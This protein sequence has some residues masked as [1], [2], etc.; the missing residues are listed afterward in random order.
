[1]PLRYM[2]DTN[3]CIYIRQQKPPA[4]LSRFAQ[5]LPEELAMSVVTFGELV[6]GVEK[7]Q[8]RAQALSRLQTL[9]GKLQVLPMPEEAAQHYGEIRAHLE[10]RGAVIGGNDLWIAAHARSQNLTLITN[11]T[12]EF[13]RVPG[14]RLDNWV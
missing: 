5:V 14:L 8:Q 11:D 12:G 3:I 7:S 9:R 2:L 13:A 6:L 1:M 10:T 4:V